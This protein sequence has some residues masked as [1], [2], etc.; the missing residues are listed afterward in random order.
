M[1]KLWDNRQTRFQKRQKFKMNPMNYMM[2]Q[3]AGS[4]Y[5]CSEDIEQC[6]QFTK[7]TF[8]TFAYNLFV[9][10][11]ERRGISSLYDTDNNFYIVIAKK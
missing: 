3:T 11:L 7:G 2:F 1:D 6:A 10:G 5:V 9:E 4:Y 8:G